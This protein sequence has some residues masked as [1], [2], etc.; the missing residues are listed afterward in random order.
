MRKIATTIV[1]PILLSLFSPFSLQAQDS[2]KVFRVADGVG[3]ISCLIDYSQGCFIK[4]LLVNGR[5]VLSTEGVNT[6]IQTSKGAFSSAK[7]LRPV[8]LRS[9]KNLYQVQ[10]IQYGGDGVTIDENWSFVP[11]ADHIIWHIERTYSSDATLEDMGFPMWNFKDLNTWKGGILDNG[12]MVWCKYLNGENATYGVHTSGV[13]Y[14]EPDLGDALRISMENTDSTAYSGA[15]YSHKSGS[16]FSCRQYVAD[17]PLKQRYNLSRSVGSYKDVFM[18][19]SVKEGTEIVTLR[20]EYQDYD[21]VYSRGDLAGVNEKAVRELLNTTARYGVV[22]NGIVGGNG[23]TTNWKCMHEPFFGQVAW[24]V[25]DPNYTANLA[26]SLNRERDHALTAEGRMLSR[27]HD[28]LG[29]EMPGTYDKETGYYE[30]KWGYTVDSQTG[31]VLNVSD[32]FAQTGDLNWIRSHKN[33]CEQV[34]DWLIRRDSNG[35]DIFEM[36][37]NSIEEQTASDWTDIVWAS[38]ENS[39]V[40][41]QMYGALVHWAD[42]EKLLGDK[43]RSAYYLSVA[44]KLKKAFNKSI[45]EGGF[46]YPEKKQYVYWR[47]KDGSIHGD[48][49][50]TPTNFAAIAYG[51]CD[52]KDRIAEILDLIEKRTTHEKLFHWPLCFDSFK[53]EEVEAGNWPFPRYENGDIFPTWGYLGVRSYAEYKPE[54]A[55]KYIRQLLHQYTLDGLSSQRYSRVTQQ[56]VGNDILSGICTS[57]TALYRDIYGIR[58]HWNQL[59]LNPHLTTDLSGTTFDYWLRDVCY[60]LSLSPDNYSV[61]FKNFEVTSSK[62]IGVSSVDNTLLLYLGGD[63]SPLQLK[64][65]G[66]GELKIQVN[67][68]TE[69]DYEVELSEKGKYCLVLDAETEDD[70]R[71]ALNGKP[72]KGTWKDGHLSYQL[73]CKAVAVVRV[74]SNELI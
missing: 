31:Y 26:Y 32:L 10:N 72:I 67:R 2:N 55:V 38:F 4:E 63:K 29:D 24:A 47:D 15:A 53:R 74:K 52:D 8:E 65:S 17:A 60:H 54:I 58:P 45:D 49:L 33:S 43:E 39:F 73:T 61:R 68:A 41:A 22:D 21:A 46:W 42:I 64:K 70:Y 14:W 51:V 27:W 11:A 1:L 36:K 57:I 9:K 23:W 50:F 30:A 66:K 62:K 59:E 19:L 7:T 37:N 56:G 25:N 13:T 3:K 6:F 12:G 35:N 20:L 16:I 44:Q 5:N 69:K 48:N 40:N 18:P 71:V 34:L 28:V